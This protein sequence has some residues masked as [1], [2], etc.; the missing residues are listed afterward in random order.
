MDVYKIPIEYAFI[1]FPFIAFILTIPFLIHQYRKFGSIPI[2]KSAIFYS[3]ILYIIC[4]Y[5]LVMLPLPSIEKVASMTGPTS[6]LIPFQFV[7]DII[8][9]TSFNISNFKDFINIFK[10][11]TIYTVLFNIILTLP[12]GIY[13]RYIFKKKWYHSIIYTFLLSLFFE[14]TQLTGLYGI[15]PRP[16]RLFDVD[17]LFINTL[18]GLMGHAITPLFTF[19]IPTIDE[20]DEKGYKKGERV[21]LIRRL[22]SLMID[23]LFAIIL[24]IVTKILLY[25]TFLEDYYLIITL[26]IFYIII[27]MLSSGKTIG[28]KV[29]K[30]EISGLESQVK[31]YQILIRN[32]LLIY[33]VIYPNSW[34]SIIDNYLKQNVVTRIWHVIVFCQVINI[35]YYIYTVITNKQ[36]LFLYESITGTKNISTIFVEKSKK[37]LE[38]NNL[39]EK[40]VEKTEK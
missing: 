10:N 40:T 35:I 1:V 11:S 15:Y 23:V 33:I 9:T 37:D 19:F 27:P 36:H 17:D 14:L 30:L 34:L 26:T 6:Q 18:G 25:N 28:K 21:T 20:L 31:W 29:I 3:M 13:L 38:K 22:V 32:I 7:K 2:L 12:F 24:S 5:F 16:Y 39:E 4:A 8:A